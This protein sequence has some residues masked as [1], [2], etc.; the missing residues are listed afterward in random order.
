MEFVELGLSA[1]P[2]L[3]D[4]WYRLPITSMV[5]VRVL[6]TR[7]RFVGKWKEMSRFY[8]RL[9]GS[10]IAEDV[11]MLERPKLGDVLDDSVG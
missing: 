7:P 9:T 8:E 1:V 11:I 6:V 3:C 10:R 2:G 5:A 4:R